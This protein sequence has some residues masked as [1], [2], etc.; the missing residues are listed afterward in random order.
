MHALDWLGDLINALSLVIPRLVLIRR[1][2]AGVVFCRD[3]VRPLK[4][5]LHIYWPIWSEVQKICTVRQTLNLSY[6]CLISKDL[7]SVVVAAIVVY[8]IDNAVAALTETDNI[9]DTIHD[10]AMNALRRVVNG[11]T[12]SEIHTN[13]R[14]T[15]SDKK[16]SIDSLLRQRLQVDLASYGV[17]VERAFLSDI[18]R[19]LFV[20]LLGDIATN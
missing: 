8:R 20:R 17:V 7:E 2:H 3:Q 14:E 15:T 12:F 5:G 11:C 6:Q 1:T 10:V 9:Q 16:Q 19:P 4:P 13:K 18:S